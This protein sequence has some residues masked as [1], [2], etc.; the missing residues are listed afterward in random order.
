MKA[1]D[2]IAA[3]LPRLGILAQQQLGLQCSIATV[4]ALR[5][6]LHPSSDLRSFT[7]KQAILLSSLRM[8]LSL[9]AYLSGRDSPLSSIALSIAVGAVQTLPI[10]ALSALSRLL[11]QSPNALSRLMN[12]HA[13]I[14]L[15]YTAMFM[16]TRNFSPF[17]SWPSWPFSCALDPSQVHP[18]P[19]VETSRMVSGAVTPPPVAILEGIVNPKKG[20]KRAL[21][22]S[23]AIFGHGF[24]RVMER[25]RS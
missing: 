24:P 8:V 12:H 25:D 4:C 10:L 14:P 13:L 21:K 15:S 3:L 11:S 17:G 5:N 18:V 6:A 22:V 7:Q 2:T 20:S 9:C 19:L 23:A 1:F 16:L